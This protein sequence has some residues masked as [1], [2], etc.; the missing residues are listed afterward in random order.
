MSFF[1]DRNRLTVPI[2]SNHLKKALICDIIHSICLERLRLKMSYLYLLIL[3]LFSGM[4]TVIAKLYN[5]K[6]AQL[7]GSS[8]AYNMI[9]PIGA[10]LAYGAAYLTD[11]GFEPGV[12]L[13]S[14]SYGL[15]YTLFTIGITGCGWCGPDRRWRGWPPGGSTRWRRSRTCNRACIRI[16][17]PPS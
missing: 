5:I 3:V 16:S 6:N 13:Y 10:A 1:T 15:F 4:V 8:S 11:P 14:L 12:L 17:R 2:F 7:E 9:Y